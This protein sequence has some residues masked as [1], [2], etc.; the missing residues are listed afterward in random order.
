M[1]I[2][3][4]IWPEQL[5]SVLNIL[6]WNSSANYWTFFLNIIPK[7]FKDFGRASTTWHVRNMCVAFLNPYSQCGS[8][9]PYPVVWIPCLQGYIQLLVRVY[10]YMI[11]RCKEPTLPPCQGICWRWVPM[12]ISPTLRV[13]HLWVQPHRIARKLRWRS[14]GPMV[15]SKFLLQTSGSLKETT[16]GQLG[17]LNIRDGHPILSRM[18]STH[19]TIFLWICWFCFEIR[20]TVSS[21]SD[22]MWVLTVPFFRASAACE[23]CVSAFLKQKACLIPMAWLWAQQSDAS[24]GA[25]SELPCQWMKA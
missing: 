17:W 4:L 22:G 1:F 14:W 15:H 24:L 12:W 11:A 16:L 8:W 2:S 10:H 20:H 18:Q 7:V 25:E 21:L 6:W 19:W 9:Q 13:L 23:S 3:D 5:R